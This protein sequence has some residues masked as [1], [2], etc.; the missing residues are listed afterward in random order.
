[1]KNAN[2]D[3]RNVCQYFDIVKVL[4]LWACFNVIAIFQVRGFAT[5][6]HAL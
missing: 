2:M 6:P 1:M 3:M 5:T 4:N